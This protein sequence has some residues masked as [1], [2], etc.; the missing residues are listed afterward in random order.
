MNFKYL[1]E[2]YLV[3]KYYSKKEQLKIR[4][5]ASKTLEYDILDCLAYYNIHRMILE[6]FL[7][8][9]LEKNTIMPKVKKMIKEGTIKLYKRQLDG[10]WKRKK[11]ND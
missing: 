6:E 8:L 10:S 1:D 11:H 4:K 5:Q 3:N 2:K 7:Q 9:T